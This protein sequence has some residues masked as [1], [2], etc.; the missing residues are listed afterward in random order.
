VP[1]LFIST[2]PTDF[3]IVGR[4]MS[5]L[6]ASATNPALNVGLGTAEEGRYTERRWGP[7][8]WLDGD[9]TPEWKAL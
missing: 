3:V 4:N 9:E 2:G 5:V 6:F 7:G 1:G 8:R